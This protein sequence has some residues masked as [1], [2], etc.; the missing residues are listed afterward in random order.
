MSGQ[1]W[2][3]LAALAGAVTVGWRVLYWPALRGYQG[4]HR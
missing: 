3:V 2:L 1:D 4:R